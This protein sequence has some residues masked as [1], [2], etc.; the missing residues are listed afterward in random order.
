[1]QQCVI[2]EMKVFLKPYYTR[3]RI[4]K[5]QYKEIMRSS[6]TRVIFGTFVKLNC[7]KFLFYSSK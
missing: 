7:A 5:E 6:V 2:S 3:R 1:M 4:T